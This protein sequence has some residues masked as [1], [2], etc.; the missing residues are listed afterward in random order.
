MPN[1][2]RFRKLRNIR[3]ISVYPYSN[4][5]YTMP[6]NTDLYAL[7]NFLAKLVNS[8][9][10]KKEQLQIIGINVKDL[11]SNGR[12]YKIKYLRT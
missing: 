4:Y 9:T 10:L 2:L 5:M 8:K 3:K 11:E 1:D 12:E 6:E 7:T